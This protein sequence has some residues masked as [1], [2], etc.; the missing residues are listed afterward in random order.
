MLP[1]GRQIP[2]LKIRAG[3][4]KSP[5]LSQDFQNILRN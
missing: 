1:D 3:I 4:P 2:L 5:R